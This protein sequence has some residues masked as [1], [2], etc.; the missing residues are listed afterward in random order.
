MITGNK[1]ETRFEC[2][3]EKRYIPTPPE[4]YEENANSTPKFSFKSGGGAELASEAQASEIGARAAQTR[5]GDTDEF[6]KHGSFVYNSS[7]T[8]QGSCAPLCPTSYL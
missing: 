8:N 3:S 1:K 5:A 2:Q 7:N 6:F 4:L